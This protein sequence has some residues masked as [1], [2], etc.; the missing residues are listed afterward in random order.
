QEW[1][2]DEGEVSVGLVCLL[3]TC[4]LTH[5]P[6]VAPPDAS[7]D[8]RLQER[9]HDGTGAVTGDGRG[10]LVEPHENTG[11]PVHGR[12]CSRSHRLRHRVDE[13]ADDLT[14]SHAA[15]VGGSGCGLGEALG[16]GL[17]DLLETRGDARPHAVKLGVHRVAEGAL[18]ACDR[19]G[20][21]D[22]EHIADAERKL[23]D[24]GKGSETLEDTAD[25]P[26]ELTLTLAGPGACASDERRTGSTTTPSGTLTDALAEEH[27]AKSTA[28]TA[29]D[30]TDAA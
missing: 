27:A 10:R 6:V 3:V 12:G 20:K 8:L 21:R 5:R 30:F 28:E 19:V 2:R 11:N 18:L 17:R 26:S 22:T 13:R 16:N 4:L 9:T 24:N 14:G 7:A 25:S 1:I 23:G 29:E 15:G